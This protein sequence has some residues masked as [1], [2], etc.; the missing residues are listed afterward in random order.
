MLR[1][2]TGTSADIFQYA[3]GYLYHELT[4]HYLDCK[5]SDSLEKPE[6]N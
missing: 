4:R 1:Y 2:G 6:T 5:P 3:F